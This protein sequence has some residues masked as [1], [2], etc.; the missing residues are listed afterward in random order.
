[1]TIKFDNRTGDDS[2]N[3]EVQEYLQKLAESGMEVEQA[4]AIG[5]GS[6]AVAALIDELK[7]DAMILV[8][9][10]DDGEIREG[11]MAFT[12]KC[13]S[14]D[15][16]ANRLDFHIQGHA[17]M[18]DLLTM[19]GASFD[20]VDTGVLTPEEFVTSMRKLCGMEDKDSTKH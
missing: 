3:D 4:I 12:D 14:S 10:D 16:L 20:A 7:P 5:S 6:D 1:M 13:G 19:I 18:G 2:I 11:I 17:A 8:R 15:K 9:E